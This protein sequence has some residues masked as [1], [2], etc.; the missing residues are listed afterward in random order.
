MS[1]INVTCVAMNAA[2]KIKYSKSKGMQEKESNISVRCRQKS[3]CLGITDLNLSAKPR[4]ARQWPSGR[5]CL[6]VPHNRERFLYYNPK[7]DQNSSACHYYYAHCDNFAFISLTQEQSKT[8]TQFTQP[9]QSSSSLWRTE[10]CIGPERV[11][12][13]LI[14]CTCT[15][16]VGTEIWFK[17]YL[18]EFNTGIYYI[19]IQTIHIEDLNESLRLI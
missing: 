2:F 13:H 16:S 1:Y 7:R 9:H 19:D 17:Q 12:M 10:S 3:P 14:L 6:S 8:W 18:F 15:V 4:D 11:K 5:N